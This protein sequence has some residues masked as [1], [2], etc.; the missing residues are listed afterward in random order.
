MTELLAI[1]EKA[2]MFLAFERAM[3]ILYLLAGHGEN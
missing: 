2:P 1:T 3:A